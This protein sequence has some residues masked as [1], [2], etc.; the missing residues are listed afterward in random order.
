MKKRQL[1][2][3][4]ILL[5]M[6]VGILGT[7]IILYAV[8]CNDGEYNEVKIPE[9]VIESTT[10][11]P[12]TSPSVT[13]PATTPSA[14]EEEQTDPPE[15]PTPDIQWENYDPTEVLSGENWALAL[16]NKN[17]KLDKSYFPATATIIDSSSVTVD[18]RVA[19]SYRIMYN[20]ALKDNIILTP[21]SGYCSYQRQ[22]T[23]Y[24]NKV[25]AFKT[26]GMS[27]TEAKLNAEKRIEPA[28]CSEN[29][30][31][32]SV[33]VVSA[34]AG[35]SSTEEYK[36]LVTNAYKYGF[37]LRYPEDKTEITGMIYQPWHWRF[38]GVTAATEMKEKNLCL[39]EYLGVK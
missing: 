24:E 34:S 5:I 4:A 26:Q 21:Y 19:E 35:F 31:G 29:N 27:E 13:E 33:D 7:L 38:V 6:L 11:P 8:F 12:V 20:D 14:D 22:Q 18:S 36:W 15:T 23:N 32:L 30:A 16:I 37:V 3:R 9:K 2:I 25:E 1:K 10:E 17:F 28:G 39:E